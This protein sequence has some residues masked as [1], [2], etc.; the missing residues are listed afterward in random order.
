MVP[1]FDVIIV[2]ILAIFGVWG[3]FTG[4]VGMLGHLLGFIFGIVISGKYFIV[5]ANFINKIFP[6]WNDQ[7]VNII[8]FLV[9]L[10]LVS[11]L[12]SIGVNLI[13][14]FVSFI[15]FVKTIN[16]LI[17]AFIGLVGGV[18]VAGAIIY[19]LSRY[20]ITPW[21]KEALLLSRLSPILL[22]LFK[23]ITFLLPKVLKQLKSLL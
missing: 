3:A 13:F 22:L 11:K 2:I 10:G 19:M 17:G 15:P 4:I 12:I 18:L 7:L 23:P 6:S 8:C 14:K 21:I 20:P 9:V 1:L 16:R 5:V